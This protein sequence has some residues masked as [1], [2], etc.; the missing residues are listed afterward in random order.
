MSQ[1]DVTLLDPKGVIAESFQIENLSPEDARSIF[2]GWVLDLPD[3]SDV[4]KLCVAL[5]NAHALQDQNHPMMRV[6]QSGRTRS[7]KQK[8]RGGWKARRGV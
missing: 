6:L 1:I 4:A 5:L 7:A 3:G 2:L 8:R